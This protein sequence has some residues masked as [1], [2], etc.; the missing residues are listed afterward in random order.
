MIKPNVVY[1]K[2]NTKYVWN[3]L[4]AS[5]ENLIYKAKAVIKVPVT[6]FRYD[7]M[8]LVSLRYVF[9]LRLT[10]LHDIVELSTK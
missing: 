5:N 3:V 4:W 9:F 2:T 10:R 1:K 6:R 7:Q 8:L